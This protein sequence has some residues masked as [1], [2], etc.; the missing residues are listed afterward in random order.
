MEA[1]FKRLG[2]Y[3][4]LPV[5]ID[6]DVWNPPAKLFRS[7]FHF[8]AFLESRE[9]TPRSSVLVRFGATWSMSAWFLKSTRQVLWCMS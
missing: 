5:L 3:D 9:K 6:P 4:Q 1:H 7:W 8:S 2:I